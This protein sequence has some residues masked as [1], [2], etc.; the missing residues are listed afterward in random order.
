[1][2]EIWA[3]IEDF[4][5]YEVSNYG[6]IRHIDRQPRKLYLNPQG[7]PTVVLF[8][9]EV[10]TRYVRQV[11]KLVLTAFGQPPERRDQNAVWHKDGNLEN[12]HINNL[13]WDRRDRVLQWNDMHRTGQ[14]KYRTPPVMVNRTG[15]IYANAF[16]CALAEG[17]IEASIIGHIERFGDY[18]DRAKYKYVR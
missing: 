3:P 9:G 12:C 15:E 13:I 14:P 7:F 5:L 4:D 1:M 2:E 10:K 18:V 17:T 6:Q 16:E 8:M 11:N